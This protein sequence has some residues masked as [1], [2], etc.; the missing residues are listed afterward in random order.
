MGDRMGRRDANPERCVCLCY[1]K[2]VEHKTY[3][4]V[5]LGIPFFLKAFLPCFTFHLY[6]QCQILKPSGAI[7]KLYTFHTWFVLMNKPKF[8]EVIV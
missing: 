8:I 5:E 4:K 1:V 2:R 6:M 7:P 3:F